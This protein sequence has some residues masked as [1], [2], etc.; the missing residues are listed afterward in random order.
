MRKLKIF[1]APVKEN[2]YND[3]ISKN[4]VVSSIVSDGS[5]FVFYKSINDIGES[6]I[7]KISDRDAYLQKKQAEIGVYDLQKK[8][9]EKE[10]K[11]INDK[12]DNFHANQ[13]EW[14]EL[15]EKAR[16]ANLKIKMSDDSTVN[17]RLEIQAITEEMSTLVATV[18]N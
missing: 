15:D 8:Q 3:F 17:S 9:A 5:I 7:D 2:D 13:A 6:L 1:F 14:K 10:L 18:S 11:E 4:L 16:N 12:K